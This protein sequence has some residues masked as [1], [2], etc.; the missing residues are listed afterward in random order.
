[1]KKYFGFLDDTGVLEHDPNQRFF[2][3]GLLKLKETA[4]FY[5]KVATLKDKVVFFY[6]ILKNHL[7]LDLIKLTKVIIYRLYY[8]LLEIYFSFPKINASIFVVDKMNINFNFPKYFISSWEAYIGYS[9]LLIKSNLGA[10]D[11]ICII[12]DFHQ[13]PKSEFK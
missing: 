1:M 10:N 4:P 12:A 3:L 5:Q 2:G 9:K 8:D 7:S 11:E 6:R 13:K